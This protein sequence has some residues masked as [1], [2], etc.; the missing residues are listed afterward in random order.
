[1]LQKD[2]YPLRERFEAFAVRGATRHYFGRWGVPR[3]KLAQS[4]PQVV[5]NFV[6]NHVNCLQKRILCQ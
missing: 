6:D 3:A 2:V 5:D 1:M 4:Y